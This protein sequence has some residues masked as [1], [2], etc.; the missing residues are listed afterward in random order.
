MNYPE[1]VNVLMEER[2]HIDAAIRDLEP[3]AKQQIS[4]ETPRETRHTVATSAP[5]T[6]NDSVPRKRRRPMSKETKRKISEALKRRHQA[7][8]TTA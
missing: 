6:S 8:S 1:L 5:S 2:N 4:T 7:Q 3:L